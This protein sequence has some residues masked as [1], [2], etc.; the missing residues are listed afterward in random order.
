MELHGSDRFG[1]T[2][3]I[4]FLF[5]SFY[6]VLKTYKLFLWIYKL[7]KV[8]GFKTY[9]D[10]KKFGKWAGFNLNKLQVLLNLNKTLYK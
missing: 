7:V 8:F 4:L 6:L 9:V 5:G 10:F 1:S 3:K 2:Y